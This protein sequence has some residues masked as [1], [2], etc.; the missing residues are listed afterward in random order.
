MSW[1]DTLDW[2]KQCGRLLVIC[3]IAAAVQMYVSDK[4]FTFFHYLM[5]V[6]MAI[7]GAYLAAAFCDWRGFSEELK[8]G[9]I[10]V[11]AYAAPHLLEALNKIA[12]NPKQV[13]TWLMKEK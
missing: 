10:G 8:T 12:E 1:F 5:G 7:F 6:L 2:L 9:V 3:L 13:I 11:A 4:K